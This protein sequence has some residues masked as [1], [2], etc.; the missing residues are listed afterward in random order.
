MTNYFYIPIQTQAC[1]GADGLSQ[2]GML[3]KQL[4]QVRCLHWGDLANLPDADANNLEWTYFYMSDAGPD[5]MGAKK[6]IDCQFKDFQHFWFLR[7][8]CM[9]HQAQLIMR[10]ELAII[11]SHLRAA[12]IPW[13]FYSSLAKFSN[14]ARGNAKAYLFV[15]FL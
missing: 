3:E 9:V 10:E 1:D 12:K 7:L 5:Q 11:D 4:S 14:L 15:H 8:E 13:T 6:Y 2:V